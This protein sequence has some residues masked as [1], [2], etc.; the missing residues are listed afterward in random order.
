MK[1]ETFEDGSTIETDRITGNRT[2][3]G[4]LA[5][6]EYFKRLREEQIY[7]QTPVAITEFC[8][9]T[10]GTRKAELIRRTVTNPITREWFGEYAWEV[11][12]ACDPEHVIRYMDETK[13][14]K[15]FKAACLHGTNGIG[16]PQTT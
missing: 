6:A 13:A 12:A 11:W 1:I 10:D 2:V 9:D 4:K 7:A 14:R 3:T 8:A 16:L 5:H 15:A